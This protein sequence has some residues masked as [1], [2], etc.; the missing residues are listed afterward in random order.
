MSSGEFSPPYEPSQPATASTSTPYATEDLLG[1]RPHLRRL[2]RALQRDSNVLALRRPAE[3]ALGRAGWRPAR[4]R[5]PRC[6]PRTACS[7]HFGLSGS[8]TGPAASTSLRDRKGGTA[9]VDDLGALWVRGRAARRAAARP[10]RSRPRRGALA[11]KTPVILVTGFLGSGKTTL[12]SRLLGHPELGETAVIVNELGE[13]GIDHHL[14]RRVD[15]RT[16]LL[17]SGLRLLHAARRPRR[18]AARPARPPRR[19]RDPAVPARRRRDDRARRPGAD[20]VHAAL[21]AGRP[22]PLR[23]RRRRRDGRRRP[24]ARGPRSR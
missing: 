19:G 22:A 17:A 5:L 6:A 21:G 9:V 10:A 11:V 20:R 18:R 2:R 8:T 1:H 4:A 23:A 3:G 16:V 13:V 7:S 15:E 24:R 12:I 14:L